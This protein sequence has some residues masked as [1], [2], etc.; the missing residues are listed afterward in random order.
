MAAT[1][2]EDSIPLDVAEALFDYVNTGRFAVYSDIMDE[3]P[4]III[5]DDFNVLGSAFFINSM[6]VALSTE[7]EIESAVQTIQTSLIDDGWETI[8]TF[9]PRPNQTG[10]VSAVQIDVRNR[11]VCH[12]EFGQLSITSRS[13]DAGNQI[14]LSASDSLTR[15]RLSC[16]QLR[17]QMEQQM[18][19]MQS[20]G[21]MGFQQNLPRLVV[22]ETSTTGRSP[23]VILGGMSSSSNGA[24]SDMELEI[25]WDMAEVYKHFAEQMAEQDWTLDTESIGSVSASGTWTQSPEENMSLVGTINVVNAGEDRFQLK[26]SV[27]ALGGGSNFRVI[28]SN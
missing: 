17:A 18:T 23:A 25:D 9:N 11:I 1:E 8:P 27:E 13:V 2:F 6:R 19:M 28:R 4:T 26:L 5:P 14:I 3:F 10:F 22:P 16:A 20:R 21:S 7:L 15:D 24:E 12:D